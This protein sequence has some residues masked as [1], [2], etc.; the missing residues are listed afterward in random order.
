MSDQR[1]GISIVTQADQL[2]VERLTARINDLRTALRQ[3]SSSSEFNMGGAGVQGL[4]RQIETAQT[5]LR[6]LHD[7][8]R[9]P[10]SAFA[11]LPENSWPIQY[12]RIVAQA[13]KGTEELV[14]AQEGF[15]SKVA[16][17]SNIAAYRRET[18]LAALETQ[19][20]VAAQNAFASRVAPQASIAAYRREE[21][22]ATRAAAQAEARYAAEL[23][24]T[25]AEQMAFVSRIAPQTAIRFTRGSDGELQAVARGIAEVGSQ[26]RNAASGLRFFV[27]AGDEIARG[28]RGQLISTIGAAFKNTGISAGG[29]AVA[30]GGFLAVMSA[31]RL[32]RGAESM[33]RWAEQTKAAAAAAGT[34]VES[35]SKLS[36]ALQLLGAKAESADSSLR[37]F[38][39]NISTAMG[40]PASRAAQSF[41][42][43]GISM[44]Q[45]KASG[46]D[47]VAVFALVSDAFQ[48]LGQNS[49][50]AT[51]LAA[52]GSEL[53]GRSIEN[54]MRLLPK[55]SEEFNRLGDEAKKLGI[56]LNDETA[57]AMEH[58][59]EAAQSLSATI[60][61][62]A[63]TAFKAWEPE[64]EAV[65]NALKSLIN[66]VGQA[67]S[68]MGNF[69]S[70]AHAAAQEAQNAQLQAG[71]IVNLA[72][73][74]LESLPGGPATLPSATSPREGR[75]FGAPLGGQYATPTVPAVGS[76]TSAYE[77]LQEQMHE[78]GLEG[79]AHG[80]SAKQMREN[81]LRGEIQ[82]LKQGLD[83]EGMN[84]KQKLEIRAQIAEKSAQLNE[85]IASGGAGAAHKEYEAFAAEERNKL[86]A[87][88]GNAQAQNEIL[89]EWR[90]KAA[91]SFGAGSAD[92][93]KAMADIQ[94]AA[95]Q[96]QR[97]QTQEAVANIKSQ[98]S[99]MELVLRTFEEDMQSRT[100][101]KGP[102]H[103]SPTQ[104]FGFDI[105]E[106][107]SQY[108]AIRAKA[109][110]LLSLPDLTAKQQTQIQ[111]LQTHLQLAEG[112]AVATYQEKMEAATDS[113]AKKVEKGLGEAF[114]K[115][116]SSFEKYLTDA[117]TR[118]TT[119]GKAG[120]QLFKGLTSS[121]I[122][123]IGDI[124][125]QAL[126]K[127]LGGT[128]GQGLGST[129]A[130]KIFSFIPG[131][132]NLGQSAQTVAITANTAAL[133][134]NTAALTANAGSSIAGGA[135]SAAGGVAGAAAGGGGFFSGIASI[136]GFAGGGLVPSAAGGMVVPG[137]QGGSLAVVHPQEMVL[138]ANISNHI[139]NSMSSASSF[140][141]A[142]TMNGGGAFSGR[143]QAENFFRRHGSQMD[144][145]AR[146][147]SRN[148]FTP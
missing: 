8:M 144:A 46:G 139:M 18:E 141:Y 131:V 120:Q 47:A 49:A 33:G 22:A 64:I 138:P 100:K 111:Q 27:T 104:A 56:T 74:Q 38:S 118:S 4:I 5:Q 58:T 68:A 72:T 115:I 37:I 10:P 88:Q 117:I 78:A 11:S 60:H 50:N 55:G 57:G 103:V 77:Q 6:S 20:L 123:G 130:S 145:M 93:R 69:L 148:R 65:I 23:A 15:T 86:A 24:K 3:L 53:F 99:D 125:S 137:T 19:K 146:S 29:A 9:Q 81:A 79:T 112:A 36:G 91:A 71:Y 80:G 94:R 136:F 31:E 107:T 84:A 109:A 106:I 114:D 2:Q 39:R 96:V 82:V 70:T 121:V 83:A 54:L 147:W 124:G 21:A 85:R 142:P 110:E 67:I 134:A 25:Q 119:A 40:D 13:K 63:I 1:I 97:Q 43:I 132:G 73:G 26:S 52:V 51:N 133:T 62:N 14:R 16:P 17:Q 75:R 116:G 122:G 87:A 98:V 127:L 135:A 76:Q 90:A 45:L 32:V 108:D 95:Q 66:V 42:A 30:V 7:V 89:D 59:G 126:A 113:I 44:D 61:G 35:Y 12:A 101:I 105:Q 102:M 28:Q 129:L 41:R 128:E 48:R 140:T 34:S 92:F 143:T